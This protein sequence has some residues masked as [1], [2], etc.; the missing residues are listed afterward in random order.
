MGV[1]SSGQAASRPPLRGGAK[2]PLGSGA[3]NR[4]R[5]GRVLALRAAGR[6]K[7]LSISIALASPALRQWIRFWRPALSALTQ[8]QELNG[9]KQ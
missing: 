6:T 8:N 7:T 4:N 9:A 5:Q 3:R 1:N 2:N